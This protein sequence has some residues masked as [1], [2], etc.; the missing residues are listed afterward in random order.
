M[1][2]HGDSVSSYCLSIINTL[3]SGG[4]L[5]LY[6]PAYRVWDWNPPFRAPKTVICLFFLSNVFLVVVPLVPPA[7]GSRVY[8]HLPYWVSSN[9]TYGVDAAPGVPVISDFSF[10]S[11]ACSSC[12]ISVI[13]RC[14]I[15]VRLVRLATPKKWVQART[16]V[17]A[18]R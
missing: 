9:P 12:N 2:T 13:N 10:Y 8:E 14:C 17:G 11:A 7:S 15:L 18:S 16:G 6:T 3:V 4:L 5:L 1:T